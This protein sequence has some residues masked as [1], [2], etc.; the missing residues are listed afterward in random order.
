MFW[1]LDIICR[2]QRLMTTTTTTNNLRTG[3]RRDAGTIA[4][5]ARPLASITCQEPSL[6][7][8]VTL[9]FSRRTILLDPHI[10]TNL[11]LRTAQRWN[12][13][14]NNNVHGRNFT[15]TMRYALQQ[16][17]YRILVLS[18]KYNNYD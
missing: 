4:E 18:W 1:L 16:V 6:L 7:R 17:E 13:H 8:T 15:D 3:L 9:H 14:D 2:G 5:L 10:V 11:Q 12:I